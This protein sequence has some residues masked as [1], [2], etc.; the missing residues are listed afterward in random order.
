V[1]GRINAYGNISLIRHRFDNPAG[2]GNGFPERKTLSL[3][4]Q[5]SGCNFGQIEDVV[6]HL[7]QVLGAFQNIA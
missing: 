3:Q 2:L 4:L 6:N 7:E 1:D 5:L